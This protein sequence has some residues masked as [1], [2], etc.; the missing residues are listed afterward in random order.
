[1]EKA[2]TPRDIA[3]PSPLGDWL[4]T[5][6]L[7]IAGGLVGIPCS[8]YRG[9]TSKGPVFLASDLPRDNRLRD[10]VILAAL[11]PEHPGQIDGVGGAE[12]LSNKV[13]IVSPSPRPDAD[14]DYTFLQLTPG[15]TSVSAFGNSVN[16]GTSVGPFAVEKGLVNVLGDETPVRIFAANSQMNY[17][18][19]V[20]TP[21]NAVT[22]AGAASID[23]VEGTSAPVIVTYR[24]PFGNLVGAL[25]PTGQRRDVVGGVPVTVVDAGGDVCM[26]FRAD[27]LGRT[28][29]ETK[30]E[31]D[32]DRDLVEKLEPIRREVGRLIGFDDVSGDSSPGPIMV[33]PPRANGTIAARK[34]ATFTDAPAHCHAAFSGSG[35]ICLTMASVLSGTV[36]F[37][38]AA[39][40][41][42]NHSFDF[43]IEHPSGCM[44]LF[45]EKTKGNTEE[46]VSGISVLRTCRKLFDG[47]VY[48]PLHVLS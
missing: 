9:A 14:V 39:I 29:Y 13:I 2:A 16:M 38:L 17:T 3:S 40:G 27:S 20:Q 19:I 7:K 28:G 34:L 30:E 23:G 12:T 4:E 42:T 47:M 25:F 18:S 35:A 24:P 37:D 1:M 36:A 8:L 43:T 33:A 46:S 21:D 11:N 26:I 6:S 41:S 45:V 31:L 44:T 48:V 22:Y 15:S 5:P 32:S 10:K